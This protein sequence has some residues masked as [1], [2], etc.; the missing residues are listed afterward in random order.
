MSWRRAHV[1][2]ADRAG[3]VNL[4]QAR[5]WRSVVHERHIDLERA[6]T[7]GSEATLPFYDKVFGLTA[8]VSEMVES[9]HHFQA[10]R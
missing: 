7:D 1:V 2:V 10:R 4:W 6:L 3:H 5:T 8:E 9:L